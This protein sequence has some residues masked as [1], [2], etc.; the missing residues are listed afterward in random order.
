MSKQYV[1]VIYRI[2]DNETFIEAIFGGEDSLDLANDFISKRLDQARASKIGYSLE[3]KPNYTELWFGDN[4]Y[5]EI[6]YRIV[7]KEILTGWDSKLDEAPW[8]DW[9]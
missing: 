4:N 7:R 3:S 6:I 2:A 5:Y 8:K 9:E 1:S